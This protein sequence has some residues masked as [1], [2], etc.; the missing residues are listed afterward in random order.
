MARGQWICKGCGYSHPNNHKE[1]FNC[2]VD[3]AVTGRKADAGSK[4]KTQPNTSSKG[5]GDASKSNK[6]PPKLTG[7]SVPPPKQQLNTVNPKASG[8]DVDAS[9]ESVPADSPE[10]AAARENLEIVELELQSIKQIQSAVAVKRKEVLQTQIVEWQHRINALKAPKDRVPGL[11][12]AVKAREAALHAAM[13]QQVDAAVALDA[14]QKQCIVAQAAVGTARVDLG[15]LQGKLLDAEKEAALLAGPLPSSQEEPSLACTPA[16]MMN[17]SVDVGLT[18]DERRFFL[19]FMSKIA[20]SPQ[21]NTSKLRRSGASTNLGGHPVSPS[22]LSPS[23]QPSSASMDVDSGST[24]QSTKPSPTTTVPVEPMATKVSPPAPTA[25]M[26]MPPVSVQPPTIPCNPHVPGQ[27]HCHVTTQDVLQQ[28]QQ[29]LQQQQAAAAPQAPA[30]PPPQSRSCFRCMSD[31]HCA[32]DCPTL[33]GN[34]GNV[35]AWTGQCVSVAADDQTTRV[36]TTAETAQ[37]INATGVKPEDISQADAAAASA[38]EA[39][40]FA[41]SLAA[42]AEADAARIESDSEDE[43][44]EATLAHAQSD[45]YGAEPPA[46]A[47]QQ[48]VASTDGLLLRPVHTPWIYHPMPVP[49]GF[50]QYTGMVGINA[51]V[52]AHPLAGVAEAERHAAIQAAKACETGLQAKAAP[53]TGPA[54]AVATAPF[55]SRATV[56]A[57]TSSPTEGRRRGRSRSRSGGEDDGTVLPGSRKIFVEAVP[58][59]APNRISP[60]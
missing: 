39:R 25:R 1:C 2:K 30:A 21:K 55:M 4:S 29:I 44:I 38:A 48:G 60:G 36:G 52:N 57:R 20:T 15:N 16:E 5:K 12:R 53:P 54:H 11:K 51:T 27:F 43:L 34:G 19:M 49:D 8:T 3:Y 58:Q 37:P 46:A 23:S 32:T 24:Q 35:S 6:G 40:S 42:A 10:M 56:R 17:L 41:Q 45:P 26:S 28:Q 18:E 9:S 59:V 14:A 7:V 31:G 13:Q 47:A 50:T 22:P 33:A